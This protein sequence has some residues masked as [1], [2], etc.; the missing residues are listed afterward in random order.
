M[1]PVKDKPFVAYLLDYLQ[2]QG[3]ERVILSVGYK[4]NTFRN[5]FG[6][7]YGNIELNYA[8]ETRQLGTGGALL[9]AVNQLK[10]YSSFLALNGDTWFPVELEK[11]F[12]HHIR[13]SG[14]I[15]IAL[16]KVQ[17][18]DRFDYVQIDRF[19][20]VTKLGIDRLSQSNNYINAGVYM[21]SPDAIRKSMLNSDRQLSIEKEIIPQM[22]EAQR[23]CLS[24]VSDT[25]FL[26]IGVPEDYACATDVLSNYRRHA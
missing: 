7:Y 17:N 11:L 20:S 26:D 1:A 16:T 23:R 14:D 3:I 25:E 15:T 10:H 5:K 12:S 18:S 9:N 6:S 2:D 24:F 13:N 22:I 19:G 21:I 8:V 4:W